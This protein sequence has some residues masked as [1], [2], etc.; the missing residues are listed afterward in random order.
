MSQMFTHKT[1]WGNKWGNNRY[2]LKI[3]KDLK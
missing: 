2:K 3:I 1:R